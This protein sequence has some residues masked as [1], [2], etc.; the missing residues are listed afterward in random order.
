MRGRDDIRELRWE[1]EDLSFVNKY[2]EDGTC[3]INSW[4][5]IPNRVGSAVTGRD[6]LKCKASRV[7]VNRMRLI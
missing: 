7:R 1:E 3:G 2:I 6:S 5:R 4:S